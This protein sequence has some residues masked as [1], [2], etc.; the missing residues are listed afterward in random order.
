MTLDEPSGRVLP[1]KTFMPFKIFVDLAMPPNA[2]QMLRE[3]TQGHQLVFP[4]K[5][6]SSVLAHPEPDPQFGA[7]DIAFGQP[8][9]QAIAGAAR[10]K[11]IHVSSSGITR[12]DNPQFRALM[13]ER[14]IPVTNSADVYNEACAVHVLSFMLAQARNLPAA[15]KTRTANGTP[16]WLALRGSSTTLREQTALILGYGA[17]GKRLV[18]LLRPFQMKILAYRRKPRGDE[19]VPVVTPDELAHTLANV[20]DHIVNILPDNQ[21]SRHFFNEA[22]LA[23][24]KPGAVFYNIGRGTTVDQNALLN[25]LRAGRLKAAWL[26]VTDPEPLPEHHP[27]LNEPNCHI[28]PHLAGGH[29]DETKT[30]V[31]HFLKNFDRFKRGEALLDRVM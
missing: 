27:L 26:D 19:G 25:A 24:L 9:P 31:G 17:I 7:A 16:E 18:E 12:Y 1:H 10:L 6:I 29:V 30:L 22:R 8:D 4:Q 28:T 14:K 11:W 21:E 5:P 23:K 2:L 13:A 15:L 20:A 3:G